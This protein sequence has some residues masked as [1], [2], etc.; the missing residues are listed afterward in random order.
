MPILWWL[1]SLVIAGTAAFIGTYTVQ[2]ALHL[3]APRAPVMSAMV[4]DVM[5]PQGAMT[6]T[7]PSWTNPVTKLQADIGPSWTFAPQATAAGKAYR[8]TNAGGQTSVTLKEQDTASWSLFPYATD[9]SLQLRDVTFPSTGQ[10]LFIDGRP[11]WQNRGWVINNPAQHVDM[12]TIQAGGKFWTE[13]T[14]SSGPA[15]SHGDCPPAAAATCAV[16]REIWNTIR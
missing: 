3:N 4:T 11:A 6:Q 16:Q 14:I 7:G 1:D 8:F 15:P 5:A 10:L 12:L 13:T 2:T 9:A